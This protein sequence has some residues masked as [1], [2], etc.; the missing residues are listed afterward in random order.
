MI[1]SQNLANLERPQKR[2]YKSVFDYFD[3]EKPL[4]RKECYIEENDIVTL[5][6]GRETTWLDMAVETILEKTSCTVT[7]VG[8]HGIG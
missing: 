7:R 2:D 4:C 3:K 6:P 5:K 8:V 1:T